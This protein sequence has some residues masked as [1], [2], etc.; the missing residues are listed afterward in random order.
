MQKCQRMYG[1]RGYLLRTDS[2]V[3]KDFLIFCQSGKILAYLVTLSVAKPLPENACQIFIRRIFFC[4]SR[5]RQKDLLSQ[6]LSE[7][8]RLKTKIQFPSS[9]ATASVAQKFFVL[10][11]PPFCI[12]DNK[13]SNLLRQN[14][15]VNCFC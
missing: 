8:S 10:F 13:V 3:L 7:N 6:I 1:W 5:K 15:Q 2:H 4:F 14:S 11:C 9:A 12:L